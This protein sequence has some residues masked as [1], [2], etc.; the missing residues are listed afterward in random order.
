MNKHKGSNIERELIHLFW[1]KNIPAIR[2]AGSG[3][4]NYPSPDVVAGNRDKKIVVECK[5]SKKNHIYLTKQEVKDL[6]NFADLFGA[7]HFIGVR[8]NREGWFFISSS[9]LDE[10]AKNFVVSLNKIKEKGISFESLTKGL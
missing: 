5:A 3:R 9:D 8:F 10:T 4:M 7:L 6:I 2:V 1:N